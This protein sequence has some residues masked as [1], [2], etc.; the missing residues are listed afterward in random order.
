[1]SSLSISNLSVRVEGKNIL[2]NVSLEVP[3][4]QTHV[5]MGP[6]GSGKSTLSNVLLG[7]SQYEVT[8]GKILIGD[9][10]ITNMSVDERAGVGLFL[11]F[12]HPESIPGVSVTNFL[13]QAMAKRKSVEDFS[14]LEVRLAVM[15]WANKLGMDTQFID[16]YLNDGFSG[17]EKKRNEVLQMALLEPEVAILDEIDSGLDIDAV[18]AV[19]EGL[20]TIRTQNPSMAVLC[21]THY[22]RILSYMEIDRV[23]ILVDGSIVKSGGPELANEIEN[24]GFDLL[25]EGAAS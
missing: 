1:M 6:N 17:G 18:A 5:L 10:D 13:R 4:G 25:K 16:R 7:N 21:I 24:E 23:H 22:Q 15:D 12:Q 9:V 3:E 2:N 8:S 20:K 11:A 19:G 14:V